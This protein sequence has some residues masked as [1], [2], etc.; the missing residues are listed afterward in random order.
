VRFALRRSVRSLRP[1]LMLVNGTKV[2]R[3]GSN[4]F[5][6]VLTGSLYFSWNQPGSFGFCD[7][8]FF[9]AA[10]RKRYAFTGAVESNAAEVQSQTGQLPQRVWLLSPRGISKVVDWNCG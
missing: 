5:P 7:G 9:A 3:S 4:Q 8:R 1:E 2:G 10:E 6:K